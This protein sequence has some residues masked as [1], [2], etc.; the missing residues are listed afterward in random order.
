MNTDIP[1]WIPYMETAIWTL[2]MYTFQKQVQQPTDTVCFYNPSPL[3]PPSINVR[4]I[5]RPQTILL[6]TNIDLGGR[7]G[8]KI[9]LIINVQHCGW[10]FSLFEL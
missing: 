6:I 7:A 3:S 9:L 4:L 2:V 10:L 8:E 1:I 5:C